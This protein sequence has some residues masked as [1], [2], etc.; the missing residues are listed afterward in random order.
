M[1]AIP[2]PI[3]TPGGD[4]ITPVIIKSGGGNE[5]PE[6]PSQVHIRSQVNIESRDIPFKE[7]VPGLSWVSSQS[8]KFGR[9]TTLEIRDGGTTTN[10]KV[11]PSEHLAS[12]TLQ[13]ESAQLIAME[14][15][16]ASE[17]KVVLLLTS[18]EVPFN[19]QVGSDPTGDWKSSST[20][21]PKKM[22]NVLLMV[23]SHEV[24]SYR[25]ETAGV[26]VRIQFEQV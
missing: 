26:E 19:R 1:S 24:V 4:P 8:T 15:G 20:T 10:H 6:D 9:I 7:T 11:E 14:S 12:V 2:A 17:H 5:D 3:V 21:F 23:G 16:I 25:C 18:P 22:T 13:F